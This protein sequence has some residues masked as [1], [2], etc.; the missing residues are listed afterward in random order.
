MNNTAVTQNSSCTIFFAD[1]YVVIFVIILANSCGFDSE[2]KIND[3]FN[4]YAKL[5]SVS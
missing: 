4:R 1:F 2:T 5:V 3:S